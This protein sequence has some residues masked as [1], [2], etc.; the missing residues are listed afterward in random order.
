M[1]KRILA[2]FLVVAIM[3]GLLCGCGGATTQTAETSDETTD[4]SGATHANE[5]TVG[6]A[7]DLDDSLDPYQ[8]SAAGTREVMFN[9]FE[10]LVKPN[11]DG[12]YVCAVASD[13]E[14]SE[15]GLT[16]T[17][18]LR[19]G[20]VFHNGEI[21]TTDDVLYSF[22]TCAATSVTSALVTALSAITDISVDGNNII[23]TLEDATP[24]FLSYVS[25]VYIVPSDYDQQT[26]AP[27]GTGPFR[28]VSRSVQENFVIERN[29]D[30]YGQGA[31]LD[32]VTYKI[33]EDNNALFTA[34]NSGALDLVAHMT[35][36]Q[37]NNL[38]NGYTIL[39]GTMN[40]VQALYLNNAVEP[41]D[42]ELV[43]QALCYAVDVDAMMELTADGHGTKLGSSMYPAFTK[44]F[45]E[46]LAERYPHDVEKAKELLK[47]AGYENGFSFTITVPS[48][49]QPHVDTAVVLVEQ[50]KE[51]GIDAQIV[52]VEWATWL[53]D[54]YANRDFEATVCGFDASTLNA[55]ALL[56]RWVSD[57]GK[58]MINYNNPE[59]DQV[60]AQAQASTDDAEQTALYKQ[61]LEILSDTAANVYLQDLADFV[62]INPAV[63]GFT[64]YPLYVIDMSLLSI[65][66]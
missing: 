46:E 47:E 65:A 28:F 38:S 17:F 34:L 20:V 27:V 2:V 10:G 33:Y 57:N 51:V 54:V 39:E 62:A 43:R 9:V 37:V 14:V 1:K 41:F 24:S 7:Q 56:N 44:Y 64:F 23:I 31:S 6:I 50:L 53:S 3:V 13:Y 25:S 45:D 35:S 40:L 30:Y 49:Y 58:N 36:D 61:C 21:C 8:M 12:D 48:N 42:N 11:S 59:Y 63:E 22:E 60:F 18:V 16:Y 52:Q 66:E 19:D 32:R 15:D 4:S 29:E 55:S 26:T 5:I